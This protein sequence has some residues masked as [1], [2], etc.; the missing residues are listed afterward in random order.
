MT[1]TDILTRFGAD[2][3]GMAHCPT[4]DDKKRSLHISA[5]RNGDTV[6]FD[7][8]G[9]KV[10]D[11]LAAKGLQLSDLFTER[12]KGN[13]RAIE[14]TYDYRDEGGELLFQVVR[15]VGKEFS[16]RR[17]DGAG[18]W[19]YKLDGV[20]RVLYH[21]DELTA[22]GPDEIVFLVEGEKDVDRLRA[23]GFVS[24]CSPMGAG[25]WRDE[26]AE[27]LA[28]RHVVIIPDNDQPGRDHAKA[29]EQS[30]H[31]VAASVK[32]LT[33]SG[34]PDKGDVSDWLSLGGTIE[35]LRAMAEAAPERTPDA[36]ETKKIS[37]SWGEL[38]EMK[39]ERRETI[40][41][42]IE[43]GEI[44]MCAAIT[45][46]GKTTLWRNIALSL[47][48]GRGFEPILPAG[49]PRTVLYLDFETR[50][51]K[52][53]ADIN[54]M[55]GRLSQPERALVAQ[56]L[57]IVADC[58]IDDKPLTLSD[59][60]HLAIVENEIRLLGADILIIDTLTAA[61]DIENE[62]DNAEAA[63]VMKKLIRLAER[64]NIVVVFLHHQGKAKQEE[65]QTAQNVHRARGGSAY[66][67]FSTAIINLLPDPQIKERNTLECA[68]I[69]GDKFP[70]TI[71]TLNKETRWFE[72]AGVVEKAPSVSD[73]IIAK[74]NGRPLKAKEI[75]ELFPKLSGRTIED[76]LKAAVK[77]GDLTQPSRGVYQKPVSTFSTA[78]IG[79]VENV[80]STQPSD[81]VEDIGNLWDLGEN[82]DDEAPDPYGDLRFHPDSE[83]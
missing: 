70:D 34:L 43:R 22:A 7:H 24:T 74:F 60:K 55:L 9:C 54:K 18:K 49:P 10:P 47:A 3:N 2:K 5:G 76:A 79:A 52:A 78:H 61:F 39:I 27:A 58:R 8:G 31:G 62:N 25:K 53:R 44:L 72:A 63:R 37:V 13:G 80:E 6:L 59:P 75:K 28:G 51:W 15:Y 4:H 20:R 38:C 82:G 40:F 65:G 81:D 66:A 32:T 33:L 26:Y 45:D 57:H 77:A 68:K 56:N 46:R 35:T 29:E 67:G 21:L 30:L 64:A 19:I 83:D 42:E 48:C 36:P 11:I 17:P 16:Q 71:L 69:K 23:G 73:Q 1:T 14:T 12:P 50:L 41:S